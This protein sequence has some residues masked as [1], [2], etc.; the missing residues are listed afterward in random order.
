MWLERRYGA[1]LEWLPYDLHPEYP[2]DGVDRATLEERY[3]AGFLDPGRRVVES[4]GFRHEPPRRIPRSMRALQLAELARSEGR[5]EHMHRRLFSAYWS[6]ARDIGEL[7][8]LLDIA[9]EVGL[10]A[11]KA[12]EVLDSDGFVD[13]VRTS[14]A[15]AHRLG[16]SGVPA[17]V[18]D[19]KVL[20]VG[21]QPHHLFDEVLADLGYPS[22]H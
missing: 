13:V 10:D 9:A 7:D 14:T 1:E 15:D 11:D 19:D 16:V 21:A 18:I 22:P 3:G 6:E 5:H 12:R 4:A 2:R 17:W 8:V 20:V